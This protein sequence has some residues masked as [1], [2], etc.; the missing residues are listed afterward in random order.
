MNLIVGPVYEDELAPV[1]RYAEQ[2]SVPVVSPLANIA[3]VFALYVLG[4]TQALMILVSRC[5]LGAMFAGNVNAL[6]FSL[7][8]GEGSDQYGIF[9]NIVQKGCN[10][11]ICTQLQLLGNNTRNSNRVHNIWLARLATLLFVSLACQQIGIIN[12][13]YVFGRA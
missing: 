8:G 9:D 4:P 10:N 5:V 13:C 3:T 7:M 2:N 12:S 6:I 1:L 11:R